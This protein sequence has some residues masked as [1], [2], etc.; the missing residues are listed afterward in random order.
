F[1]EDQECVFFQETSF[2]LPYLFFSSPL[3]LFFFLSP[4]FSSQKRID[5]SCRGSKRGV[6]RT[7]GCV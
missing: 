1:T 6:F 7:A 3:P 4:F 2:L 5:I